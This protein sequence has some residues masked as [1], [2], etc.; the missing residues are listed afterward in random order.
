MRRGVL[1]LV[2]AL[3][4]LGVL[5]AVG[6]G[7]PG[8]AGRQK[9]VLTEVEGKVLLAR[10]GDALPST[11]GQAL[12]G[13]EQIQT[14]ERSRA[15]LSFGDETRIRVGESASLEVVAVGPD[16]VDIEL[17]GGAVQATVRPTASPVRIGSRG[18]E[19][20]ATDAEFAVAVQ[21]EAMLVESRRGDLM[22]QGLPGVGALKEGARVVVG[23]GG[24]EVMPIPEDLLLDVDWPTDKRTRAASTE[25]RGTTAPGARVVVRGGS[26]EVR[27]E[28]SLDGSFVAHL[29]LVEGKNPVTVEATDLF[30]EKVAVEV[31][32]VRDTQGPVFRGGVQ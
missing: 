2:A 7:M 3:V 29:S 30:G 5:A 16:G 21:G 31:V 17:E 4:L 18:R 26:E 28:A 15:V 22:T 25:V 19:V 13:A 10:D 14:G 27:A 1:L 24:A 11:V 8:G 12:T 23:M 20:Q 9:L 32:L 6:T